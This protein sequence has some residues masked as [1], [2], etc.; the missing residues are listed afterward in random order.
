[1]GAFA[2]GFAATRLPDTSLGRPLLGT[3]F[4]GGLTTFSTMQVEILRMLEH[5]RLE[6]AGWYTAASVTAGLT[7]VWVGVM[8]ARR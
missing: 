2:L 8:V 5:G 6:L 1:V 3:G 7:A 4:C